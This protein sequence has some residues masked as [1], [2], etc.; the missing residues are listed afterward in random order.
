MHKMTLESEA[1]YLCHIQTGC[2]N[3]EILWP[4]PVWHPQRSQVALTLA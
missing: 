4:N 2:P 3:R 1:A